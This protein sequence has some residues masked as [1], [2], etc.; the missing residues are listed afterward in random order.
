MLTYVLTVKI[1]ARDLLSPFFYPED[2][3]KETYL[4][5]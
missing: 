1:I 3:G 4:P 2:E 5:S